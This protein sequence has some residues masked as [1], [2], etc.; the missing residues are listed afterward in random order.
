M[1]IT[2]GTAQGMSLEAPPGQAV[3]PTSVRARR[4][5]FGT[6]GALNGKRFC[7]L[8]AGS[9]AV[10]IEAAS[11]GA[12]SVL[13]VEHSPSVLPLL[14]SNVAR[15]RKYCPDTRFEVIPRAIPSC[16]RELAARLPPPGIIFA[17]PP[18]AHSAALLDALLHREDFRRWAVDAQVWWQ[19]PGR[20]GEI[21]IFP[22][23][24]LLITVKQCGHSRFFVVKTAKKT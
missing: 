9:G 10:G 23:E 16:C 19:A 18:Y 17:D 11:R 12:A 6:L 22:P 20:G 2:G 5:L 24:W 21:K 13:F 1:E 8:C 4:A 15:A 7:D 3:R 14:R